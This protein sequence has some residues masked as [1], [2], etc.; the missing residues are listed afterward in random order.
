MTRD[1]H[2]QFRNRLLSAFAQDDLDEFFPDLEAESFPIRQ[3]IYSEGGLI[4]HVYFV[5]EGLA[6]VLKGMENGS[7]IEVGMIGIEGMVGMPALL[8]EE[9]SAHQIIVQ[10]PATLLRMEAARCKLAFD[11][12]AAVRTIVHRFTVSFLNQSAQTA[13]CNRLHSV[14]QRC[15]RWLLMS[16]DRVQSDVMAMTHE[17]LSVMLGVRRAGVSEIA[18]ELQRSGI[19]QYHRGQLRIVDREALEATACE[20]YQLDRARFERLSLRP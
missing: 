3:T 12:S 8:G 20:C 10:I 6:S 4:E 9:I 19:I 14:E 1:N 18:E 11:R 16:S 7:T 17:F 15:A 5:E 13:A 2:T